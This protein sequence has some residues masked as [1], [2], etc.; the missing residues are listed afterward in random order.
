MFGF[1][2]C[3]SVEAWF[4]VFT[5]LWVVC[6]DVMAQF[7]RIVVSHAVK[8]FDHTVVVAVNMSVVATVQVGMAI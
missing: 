2:F 7:V 6:M 8:R 4:M 3:S 1:W 5:K